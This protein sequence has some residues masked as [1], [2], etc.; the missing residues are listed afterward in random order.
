MSRYGYPLNLPSHVRNVAD[1]DNRLGTNTIS[2]ES[3]IIQE[4]LDACPAGSRVVFP[5]RPHPYNIQTPLTIDKPL[6]LEGS[7]PSGSVLQL[8]GGGTA[9]LGAASSDVSI[10]G[11]GFLSS[12]GTGLLFTAGAGD[13]YHNWNLSDSV[14]DG[15]GVHLTVVGRS[16]VTGGTATTGTRVGDYTV[17][18]SCEFTN[19]VGAYTIQVGGVKSAQVDKCHLHDY[20]FDSN[21]GEGVKVLAE[22]LDTRITACTFERSTRDGID[23]YDSDGSLVDRCVFANIGV[24]PIEAKNA[25]TDATAVRGHRITNNV[26]RDCQFWQLSSPNIVAIGNVAIDFTY[27]TAFRFGGASASLKNPGV[28]AIGNMV[29]GAAGNGFTFNNCERSIAVGNQVNGAGGIGVFSDSTFHT[30]TGNMV[31]GTTGAAYH[32]S[33]V[34][35]LSQSGDM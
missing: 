31:T 29:F 8:T 32:Y 6:T 20:G 10:V 5:N 23:L 7:D 17:I 25:A 26:A 16:L 14:F 27:A 24:V 21:L 19:H 15:V 34:G 22:S 3:P 11:L 28:T 18:E 13:N 4:V 33:S 9:F 35:T 12:S 1:H 30:S 2:N